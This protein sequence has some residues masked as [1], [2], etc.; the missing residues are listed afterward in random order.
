MTEEAKI[1]FY[2]QIHKLKTKF[3]LELMGFPQSEIKGHEMGKLGC[4]RKQGMLF[5]I[6]TQIK[7]QRIIRIARKS[8]SLQ[9][10]SYISPP[11]NNFFH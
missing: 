4:M 1:Q 5:N 6:A 11:I 3:F 8:K 7:K 2:S 9:Q 10:Y